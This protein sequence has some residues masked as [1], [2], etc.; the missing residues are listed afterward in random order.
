MLGKLLY[1]YFNYME[2]AN[3]AG[4]IDEILSFVL[5]GVV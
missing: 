3:S 2:F 5:E 4:E 1:S